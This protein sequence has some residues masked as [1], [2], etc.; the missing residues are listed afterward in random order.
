MMARIAAS[1]LLAWDLVEWYSDGGFLPNYYWWI[2][3]L[4]LHNI[5]LS[6]TFLIALVSMLLFPYATVEAR[7]VGG[8]AVAIEIKAPHR[9]DDQLSVSVG[10][11]ADGYYVIL[12]NSQ[13]RAR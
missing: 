7:G 6:D 4:S 13:I 12:E 1:S 3:L 2:Q 11:N 5:K 9:V 10:Q 8:G